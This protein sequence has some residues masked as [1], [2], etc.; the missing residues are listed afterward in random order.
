MIHPDGISNRNLVE[1]VYA[2]RIDGG[3]LWAATSVMVTIKRL[4]AR[5]VPAGYRVRA[6]TPGAGS[7]YKLERL[8]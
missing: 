3:P 1:R 7:V 5:L 4:S 2:D 8:A 6:T